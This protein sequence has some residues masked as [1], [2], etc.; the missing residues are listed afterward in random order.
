MCRPP[1]VL[2][3]PKMRGKKKLY[4][5]FDNTH[6]LQD[7]GRRWS[8]CLESFEGECKNIGVPK[9]PPTEEGRGKPRCA[10]LFFRH[11]E[12]RQNNIYSSN[13][14]ILR[15]Q[16]LMRGEGKEE[17]KEK[18]RSQSKSNSPSRPSRLRKKKKERG[19][20]RR[21]PMRIPAK[22][23]GGDHEKKG[24]KKGGFQGACFLFSFGGGGEGGGETRLRCNHTTQSS[25]TPRPLSFMKRGGKEE[26]EGKKNLQRKT[27][28]KL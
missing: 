9:N 7:K 22:T 14:R 19:L 12:G 16:T 15:L 23:T 1:Q 26:K 28:S 5:T 20:L 27:L 11:A 17:G 18:E 13:R 4:C 25:H 2:C 3:M 10:I 21:H 24:K 8:R 6:N